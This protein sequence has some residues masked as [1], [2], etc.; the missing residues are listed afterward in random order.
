MNKILLILTVWLFSYAL[1][2]GGL[3][4]HPLDETC[5]NPYTSIGL[6]TPWGAGVPEA[7]VC[8]DH[9]ILSFNGETKN[10]NW[11]MEFLTSAKTK[12]TAK[13]KNKFKP[14]TTLPQ[15]QRA[16]LSDFK[17]SGYDRGHQA[18]AADFK[19]DQTAMDDSFYLSNMSPQVGVGFNRGTWARLEGKI[20]D[21][22][23]TYE[24][25]VVI[26]GPIFNDFEP[27]IGNNKVVVPDEFYKIAFDPKTLT[28]IA[29]ILPNV[30]QPADSYKNHMVSIQ[31]IER[32]TGLNFF[33]SLSFRDQNYFETSP[34]KLWP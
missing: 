29:F 2:P 14:D 20:R 8:R 34:S 22:A 21:W 26:T 33:P 27:T 4:G 15:N 28:A 17:G 5:P 25:L 31:T 12:G 18:P 24:T 9:Y 6:P 16:E 13:R 7:F 11:V 1:Q 30:R 3:R 19:F 32:K 23:E 10:P